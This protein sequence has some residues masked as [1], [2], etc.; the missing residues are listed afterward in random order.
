MHNDEP[1]LVDLLDRGRLIAE[2]GD[3]IAR[4]DPP[5]VFGVHG[6]WG[7]GKTS[8]LHQVQWYI[9]GDCPQ[10]TD[11]SRRRASD[12]QELDEPTK[13]Y[14]R[15]I[16]TVWFDAWRYQY[17]DAPVVAL[18]HEI[19]AQLTW[20]KRVTR[21]AR[22]AAEVT[23]RG[24]LLSMDEVAKKIGL[25]YSKFRDASRDWELKNLAVALPSHTLRIHLGK[26]IDTL[27]PKRAAGAP[28]PRLAVFIDDLDRCEP[29]AA[30]RLLEGLKIYLTLDN[31][32]FVLGMNQK[33]VE[34]AIGSR[35]E[36]T[37]A[38]TADGSPRAA[39]S[40]E[41]L[42]LR[43]ARHE[44]EIKSRAAAYLE[45]LCQNV[46]RLPAVREPGRLLLALL[47]GTVGNEDIRD[48][49]NQA[50]REHPC[51]PP[52]PR[53]IKGFANL[54]GRF[55]SRLPMTHELPQAVVLLEARLMIIVAYVYQFHPELYVR[56]E[57]N[58]AL[59]DRIR[60]RCR[61][62]ESAIPCLDALTLPEKI[63]R[64][65][66]TPT[67][68]MKRE[69]AYPDPTEPSVF[70]IQPMINSLDTEVTA[71]QFAPYLHGRME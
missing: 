13:S 68:E 11:E 51:A 18:L 6:D 54:I 47:E 16:R 31:C 69:S 33:A 25:Q 7:L 46:W 28:A 8:F 4:C 45:K 38:E 50:V 2:V 1:T 10:Q 23:V 20:G 30:Y 56:W 19:R 14:R 21:S 35:L 9:T 3:A 55:S 17:E 26:A 15:T 32:V 5:Q 64:D 52:N 44:Q 63:T 34:V 37:A 49:I 42:R 65:E 61:G 58:P 27:L 57:S 67:P 22:R 48:Y 24:A 59:Y 62:D 43:V 70:W 41:E 60:D 29:E 12:A 40:L 66:M 39:Q 71:E 36:D 53:R